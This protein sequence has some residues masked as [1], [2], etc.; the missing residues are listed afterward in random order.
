MAQ[1]K[2]QKQKKKRTEKKKSVLRKSFTPAKPTKKQTKKPAKK[3]AEKPAGKSAKKLVRKPAKKL[4][5]KPTKKI[6]SKTGLKP[7]KKEKDLFKSQRIKI[8]I[9]GVGGGASSIINEIARNL[10]GISFLIAD[11]DQRS[12]KRRPPGVRVFPFGQELTRGWG[13]GMNPELGLMAAQNSKDKIKKIFQDVDLVILI[14]CLGG[15]VSSGASIAFSQALKEEK[16]L[17]IGIFTLPFS[18]EG[19]KKEKIALN[20]LKELK[21]NLSG[22]IVLPNEEILKQ[23]EKKISL[24]KSL[25]L[26]NQILIDYLRDLIEMLSQIGIIN[27]DFADLR[28]ILKGK[29]Q[30]VSFGRGVAQGQN[31]AEDALKEHFENP[32]FISPPRIKKILFNISAS[33]DL[34]LKEVE[35]IAEEVSS[36]NPKAKII[37]GI[38][39]NPK[40]GKKIKITS[41]VV[42]E[43]FIEKEE[44]KEKEEKEKRA[45]PE[46]KKKNVG[47]KKAKPLLEKKKKIKIRRSALEVKKAEEEE[48][49]KE[50]FGEEDWEI[51]SFLRR[52]IE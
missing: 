29:G 48:K 50:W 35:K 45:E 21:E 3:P 25:S 38:S 46:K 14:S 4:E 11:T 28:T 8:Q 44:K 49:E 36:L 17:S 7:L 15:G 32:F 13:T 42:G 1:K 20:S 39:Y 52:K 34:K 51:P 10:K 30:A 27:I 24:K 41:L 16:K 43:N 12:F 31:R 40:L 9:I 2:N 22:T 33:R 19:E 26:M 23:A 6:S 37:F 18:F 5:K 47:K